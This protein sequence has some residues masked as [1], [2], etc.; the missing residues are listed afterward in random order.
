MRKMHLETTK[1]NYKTK[2]QKKRTINLNQ[3]IR[4]D[5]FHKLLLK[6]IYLN[7]LFAVVVVVVCVKQ[8]PS[9]FYPRPPNNRQAY[10][11]ST[12]PSPNAF[13]CDRMMKCT[14]STIPTAIDQRLASTLTLTPYDFHYKRLLHQIQFTIYAHN[15]IYLLI[16]CYLKRLAQ[17]RV[18]HMF[19]RFISSI[20][21][22]GH[23]HG[24]WS[25]CYCIS[26]KS[27]WWVGHFR[28]NELMTTEQYGAVAALSNVM[29]VVSKGLDIWIK[30][31]KYLNA[32][33]NYMRLGIESKPQSE[34]RKKKIGYGN[35]RF[36]MIHL[37]NLTKAEQFNNSFCV[38]LSPKWNEMLPVLVCGWPKQFFI[39]K[40]LGS[41]KLQNIS[42][43]LPN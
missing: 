26:F 28:T 30:L 29:I 23:Q 37:G 38:S 33:E 25:C 21:D 27:I 10:R 41:I 43:K 34:H 2:H 5:Y 40:V 1:N 24:L 17:T 22:K 35:G 14:S 36:I 42:K 3:F 16:K 15:C 13:Q 18:A 12:H 9:K 8:W 19:S 39:W 11:F 4:F 20:E 7:F 6:I 32:D 31:T